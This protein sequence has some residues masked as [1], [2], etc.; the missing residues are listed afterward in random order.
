MLPLGPASSGSTR[1]LF[2]G[3][4]EQVFLSNLKGHRT[5]NLPLR[6]VDNCPDTSHRHVPYKMSGVAIHLLLRLALECTQ[7]AVIRYPIPAYMCLQN[8]I[9]HWF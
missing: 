9:L 2:L 8:T 3:E 7:P 1:A 5:F 6:V 4:L